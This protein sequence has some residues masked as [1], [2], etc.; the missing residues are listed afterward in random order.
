[1]RNINQVKH[2]YIEED[3]RQSILAE[4]IRKRVPAHTQI[5]YIT[6]AR[7]I[8]NQFAQEGDFVT[9]DKLL[10]YSYPGEQFLSSCPG[11]N[12]MV[13]CQYFVL[14]LGQGCLFDCHYCYLQ[15]F[16]NNPLMTLFGN[17]E[18]L[19]EKLDHKTRGKKFHFRIGTG[20]YTDSLALEP[21]TGLASYLV[22]YFADHPNATLELK[23]K[24]SNVDELLD[25]NH[26]RH[27]VI[28]WSMNPPSIIDTIEEGTA[29]LEER[30]TAAKKAV[31]AGYKVA[32]HLDPLVYFE[33]WEKQYHNLIDQ[34]FTSVSPDD[35]AWISA[36]SFR[37]T[38]ALKAMIQA[39]FPED[40]LTRKGEM[41]KGSD[42]KH[43]YFKTVRQE[44]FS[45]IKTKI[46]S[47]DPRLF[48]YL[49]ME[50]QAMWQNVFGF[51]PESGKKLDALF[52]QRRQYLA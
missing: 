47:V 10:V 26:C 6:D 8:L 17:L 48:L 19:F 36:G 29:S 23:T 5:E 24:S 34:I 51:V 9:K 16:L 43:R 52:E 46:E 27:T 1:M 31:S 37:Y 44:M 33:D 40:E 22:N 49:C 13:C 32:F 21:L 7:Q 41:I 2:I 3:L 25:L 4:N 15:S 11:S 20:E 30:L 28:S 12:G 18:Q 38:A 45:S 42:G 35:V 50:S 39:R 14:H